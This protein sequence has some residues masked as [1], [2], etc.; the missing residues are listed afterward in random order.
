MDNH[1]LIKDDNHTGLPIIRLKNAAW[2]EWRD[3][4]PERWL[5]WLDSHHF[6]LRDNTIITLPDAEHRI[7]AVLQSTSSKALRRC[8]K[9][10]PTTSA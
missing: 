10:Q 8:L 4:A 7:E 3:T 9:R 6:A 2:Q 1:H 5:N